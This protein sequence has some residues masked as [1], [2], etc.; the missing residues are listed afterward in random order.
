MDFKETMRNLDK[1]V[2]VIP[3]VKTKPIRKKKI[4]KECDHSQK[5]KHGQQ[6]KVFRLEGEDTR[7]YSG[8][9]D[10]VDNDK[11]QV[12]Y[13]KDASTIGKTRR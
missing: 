9:I 13:A 5:Y 6:V 8:V 1:D 11:V 10:T 12:Y 2:D 4:T 3:A 7:R